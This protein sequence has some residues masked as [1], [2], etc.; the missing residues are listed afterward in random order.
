MKA[1]RRRGKMG[2]GQ[3][4]YLAEMAARGRRALVDLAQSDFADEPRPEKLAQWS[5]QLLGSEAYE[6][7]RV[8]DRGD[9]D[10]TPETVYASGEVHLSEDDR[11][12][13]T[14]WATAHAEDQGQATT[15]LTRDDTPEAMG[16]HVVELANGA[17][18]LVL[19]FRMDICTKKFFFAVAAWGRDNDGLA[20]GHAFPYTTYD[21]CFL[22]PLSQVALR[23]L[24]ANVEATYAELRRAVEGR[25]VANA[26]DAGMRL[27]ARKHRW[28]VPCTAETVHLVLEHFVRFLGGDAGPARR[29][30]GTLRD[31]AELLRNAA[32]VSERYGERQDSLRDLL[33]RAANLL[34]LDKPGLT[35]DGRVRRVNS[36]LTQGEEGWY[37]D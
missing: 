24:T 32:Y 12:K 9:A 30:A 1:T 8:W 3:A 15:D 37:G 33:S 20:A 35:Y 5:L 26:V 10:A 36:F 14:R 19:G 6:L 23:M 28:K 13:V 17:K 27:V 11:L 25:Q 29:Q 18:A 16:R 7:L 34:L 31:D 2:V 4:A 22:M 21:E